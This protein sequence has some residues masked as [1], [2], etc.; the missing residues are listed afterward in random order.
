MFSCCRARD[1][2]PCHRTFLLQPLA[3]PPR[4]FFFLRLWPKTFELELDRH[5]R[6]AATCW[7]GISLETKRNAAER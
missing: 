6:A 5:E 4:C 7:K 1:V 2:P 3:L